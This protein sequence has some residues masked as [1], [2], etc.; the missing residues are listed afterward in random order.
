M[1]YIKGIIFAIFLSFTISAQVNVTTDLPAELAKNKEI[2]LSIKFD[3]GPIRN[4]SK[5]EMLVPEGIVIKEL[6]C[7]Y[8]AF[9]FEN[10]K[11]RVIWAITP[12]DPIYTIQVKFFTGNETGPK[13]IT[14][15]YAY[16]EKGQKLELDMAKIKFTVVDSLAPA[17]TNNAENSTNVV[18]A[19]TESSENKTEETRK[20]VAEI[21]NETKE[22]EEIGRAEKVDA[23]KKIAEAKEELKR[24]ESISNPSEQKAAVEAANQKQ[25]KA[26]E[27]LAA[28]ER[29]LVLSNSLNENANN[30]EKLNQPIDSIVKPETTQNVNNTQAEGSAADINSRPA[31]KIERAKETAM[32]KGAEDAQ[33]LYKSIKPEDH[34][35]DLQIEQQVSQLRL[36]SKDALEV[37][38][39]EKLKA[40]T[41]LH[42]A[43]EALKKTKYIPD[44]EEKK[45]AVDKA[46]ADIEQAKSDLEIASKILT[47][48]KSLEENAKEIERLHLTDENKPATIATASANTINTETATAIAETPKENPLPQVVVEEKTQEKPVENVSQTPENVQKPANEVKTESIASDVKE[49]VKVEPK[50]EEKVAEPVKEKPVALVKE[51]KPAIANNSANKG[52]FTLQ[53]GSFVNN[54]DL[55]VFKKLGKVDLRNENGKYKVY[56]GKFLSKEE[57]VEMRQKTVSKGFDCFVVSLIK[58]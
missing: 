36:D 47:L 25:R 56:Y 27:E 30:K 40:E 7:R 8:G 12:A 43:Y 41:A 1:K 57:A 4:Y 10:N 17:N 31:E 23:E 29:I 33:D 5:Y 32:N 26:E 6:D 19:N 2:T 38:T 21:K 3:K 37:G 24:A 14:Q 52:N 42:D 18:E 53:L 11:V 48:S 15:T 13:Q 28:A 55:S 51:N 34:H 54:P 22:A 20:E 50:I 49:N 45:L 35:E 46:N 58:Q 16:A 44:A 39:R 9:S